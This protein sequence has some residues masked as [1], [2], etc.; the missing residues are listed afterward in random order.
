MLRQVRSREEACGKIFAWFLVWLSLRPWRWRRYAH[1]KR[2]IQEDG[3]LH[4]HRCENLKYNNLDVIIHFTS[5]QRTRFDYA[6]IHFVR[7]D[8]TFRLTRWTRV[9]SVHVIGLKKAHINASVYTHKWPCP[10]CLCFT[11]F[12]NVFVLSR[13]SSVGIRLRTG[14][15][16]FDSPQ[17]KIFFSTGSGAHPASC[18]M[19]TGAG[20][21][22][23]K[24]QEHKAD[25]SPPSGVEVK[26]DGAIP[27][28]PHMSSWHCA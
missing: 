5:N 2:Y 24:R 3:K 21:P 19:G 7:C 20:S 23:V 11:L 16:G 8:F 10:I 1:S 13:D 22:G 15:P 6:E 28:L 4:S 14:R 25:H 17:Y 9:C 27:P 12:S 26:N 18:L